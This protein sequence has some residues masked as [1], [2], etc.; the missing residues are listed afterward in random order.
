MTDIDT[1]P[2][3]RFVEFLNVSNDLYWRIDNDAIGR[4]LGGVT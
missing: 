3:N 1:Q 2:L 4:A